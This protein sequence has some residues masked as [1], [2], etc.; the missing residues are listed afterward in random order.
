MKINIFQSEIGFYRSATSQIS[1]KAISCQDILS[2][3]IK[4]A[5]IGIE[6]FCRRLPMDRVRWFLQKKKVYYF[7][8]T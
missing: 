7:Q 3:N 8:L 4:R 1:E 6:R 2:D 5:L